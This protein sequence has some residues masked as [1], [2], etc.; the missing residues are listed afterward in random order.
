MKVTLKKAL[1]G[2]HLPKEYIATSAGEI[3][4]GVNCFVLANGQKI[5]AGYYLFYLNNQIIYTI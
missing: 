3:S 5:P 2:I 1:L 4:D